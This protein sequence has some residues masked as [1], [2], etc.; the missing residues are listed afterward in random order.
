MNIGKIKSY[1][2]SYAVHLLYPVYFI[3]LHLIKLILYKK[4][5][6]LFIF[7]IVAAE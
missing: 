7:T 4:T 1:A 2:I 5:V 3:F 6:M